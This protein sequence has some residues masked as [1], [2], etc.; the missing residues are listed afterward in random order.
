VMN[1]DAVN[2][3]NAERVDEILQ[4]EEETLRIVPVA[5]VSECADEKGF[6]DHLPARIDINHAREVM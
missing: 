3:W 5:G 6:F 1:Q 2:D 4:F